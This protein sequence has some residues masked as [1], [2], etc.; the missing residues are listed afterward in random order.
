MYPVFE[1]FDIASV[2][3]LRPKPLRIPR[4][5]L[6]VHLGTLAGKLRLLGFDT[7]YH[8]AR[9]DAELASI[10]E[11][12]NRILLTKD[13]Q[14]LMRNQVSRGLFIRNT[15]TRKQIFEVI[16][17]LDLYEMIKPL[18]R[19][20]IC[21]GPIDRLSA[22]QLDEPGIAE[23]IPEGVLSWCSVFFQCSECGRIYWKGSHY[24][25]IIEFIGEIK[26]HKAHT[27]REVSDLL[28]SGPE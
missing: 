9:S 8:R 14:L 18:S 21:N 22:T 13:R 4:F 11:R 3:R 6:D 28:E 25:K 7:L 27:M 1:R 24:D 5:L 26:S 12:E 10:A 16:E 20:S 17:R 15:K 2:T 23:K 19:C